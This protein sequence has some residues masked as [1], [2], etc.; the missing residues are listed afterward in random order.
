MQSRLIPR[1][2][3]IDRYVLREIVAPT[4]LS[5][6]ILTVAIVAG[7]LLKL[8]E[9]VVNHG[10]S[11]WDVFML[12]AYIMPGFLELTL[13]MALLAGVLM[14]FGRMSTDHELTAARACGVSLYRLA[15]P[16]VGLGLLVY[17]ISSWFAFSVRP[18]ANGRL[19]DRLYE[20]TRAQSAAGL[21]EK[22]FN[23][24]FPGLV[25]YADVLAPDGRSL[26]G[27]L[28]SDGRNPAHQ[29]AVI[30]R[31]GALLADEASRTITL[32]LFDGSIFG[33]DAQGDTSNVTHFKT[34][35]LNIN[36]EEAFGL[37][38]HDVKELSLGSLRKRVAAA[39]A[40]GQPDYGAEAE[41][42]S[43]YTVS[44]VAI[45]FALLGVSLGLKPAR[46]G[47]SE[48]FGVSVALFFL[49]Y[50]LLRAGQTLAEQARLNAFVALS[51][52]DVVFIALTAWLFYR[53]ATDRGDQGRGAGD[54]LWELIGR[55]ER[56]LAA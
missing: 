22:V 7:R 14:G 30:A 28:I 6:L 29:T 5:V 46:G 23:H 21:K 48:R 55:A 4:L 42:A 47:Q 8:T 27:V 39:R 10:V 32:R 38:S 33:V 11:L 9:M 50:A 45:M 12:I 34:Y 37:A 18:L 36:P 17:A 41:L 56:R 49:Y 53:S 52:P 40:A 2:R 1:L 44:P 54:L 13:P 35:D 15:L 3:I 25:I 16:V 20:L 43:R 51:I 24:S 19:R 26:E 31:R